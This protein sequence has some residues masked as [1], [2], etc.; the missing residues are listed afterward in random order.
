MLEIGETWSVGEAG[1]EG[2]RPPVPLGQSGATSAASSPSKEIASSNRDLRGMSRD[3][4]F[5][6]LNID[7]L[8]NKSMISGCPI[9]RD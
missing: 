6:V 8:K 5:Q 1:E 4:T 2:A 3:H 7:S 9:N